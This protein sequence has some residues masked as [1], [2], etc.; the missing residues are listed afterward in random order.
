MT[1]L[2]NFYTKHR[3]LCI[4]TAAV[5]LLVIGLVVFLGATGQP[6]SQ[7]T[8]DVNRT[9][10]TTP[11]NT[12]DNDSKQSPDNDQAPKSADGASASPSQTPDSATT[13]SSN[14]TI[15]EN[16]F[17]PTAVT[18]K[19]GTTVTWTNRDTA[20]H[21]LDPA[22]NSKA[23]PHSPQLQTGESY[24]YTYTALG[25]FAYVDVLKAGASGTVTVVE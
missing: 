12:N 24:T 1:P 8:S 21:A 23:G 25:S 16:G 13:S 18:I 3:L 2:K 9:D 20:A 17:S 7:T 5:I 4:G 19:R 15:T 11:A 14:V 22:D 10:T 6:N